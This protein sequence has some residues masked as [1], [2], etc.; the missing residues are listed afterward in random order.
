MKSIYSLTPFTCLDYPNHLA[1][2]VWF[3]GCNMRCNY[4]YNPEI[5]LGKGQ[6]TLENILD[7]LKTRQNLLEAVVLSGGEPTL[8]KDIIPWI[9]E[10][11]KMGFKVKL[12]TNGSLPS[13]VDE[14]LSLKLIDY[15]ALDFKSLPQ[16]FYKITQ[17]H[18]FNSFVKTLDLLLSNSIL[19][20]VRSTIHSDFL[21]ENEIAEM[22]AFLDAKDYKGI[23]YLQP[24]RNGV[25]TIGNL[26]GS[27]LLEKNE[28]KIS[29]HFKIV[30]RG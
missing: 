4:C 24:F 5:V 20:E 18:F 17:S 12:D 15:V 16:K 2:I 14:L 10:I 28:F 29:K 21:N 23:Y 25:E 26:K 9:H 8:H 6:F 7:F 19:F 22:I 30:W 3:S 1:C 11:K 13:V 27:F